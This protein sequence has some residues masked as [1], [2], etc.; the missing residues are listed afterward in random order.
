MQ[1][2]AW[3]NFMAKLYGWGAA[4]VIVGA[5]FKIQHWKGADI[6]LIVGLG[7]EAVIFFISAFEKAHEE[8]DWSLVYPELA[9]IAD[10]DGRGKD[11][12]AIA[13][14]GS[15]DAVSQELDKLLS[16]AKI[17]PEL[18]ESLGQGM[19]SL[20]DSTNKMTNITDATLATDEYVANVKNASQSVEKL[21][22]SYVKASSSLTSVVVSNDEGK[23][24]GEQ[25]SVMSKKLAELNSIYDLQLQGSRGVVDSTKQY[26]DS[27][28]AL[29]QNLSDSVADTKR[30]KDEIA[31]LGSNLEALNTVYGNM[32]SAMNFRK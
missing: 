12:K 21:A 7:T 32:L 29:M 13:K 30:Y 10:G 18:I 6:M 25:L 2:K 26:F 3:K 27:V 4:V 16:E 20:A 24:Y 23:S 8:Y 17:G 5:L 15:G 1:S 19:R 9:G 14:G 31:Q 28:N 22:E 11:K